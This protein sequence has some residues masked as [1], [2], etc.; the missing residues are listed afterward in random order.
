MNGEAVTLK[1]LRHLDQGGAIH[2][3]PRMERQMVWNEVLFHFPLHPHRL[4]A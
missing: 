3:R 1:A 2:H 4:L